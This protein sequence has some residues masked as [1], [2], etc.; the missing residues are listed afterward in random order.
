MELAIRNVTKR[1]HNVTANDDVSLSVRSGQVIAL[2]GENGA[3]KSTLMNILSGLHQADSGDITIDGVVQN[4]A[5][6]SDA[7]AAGIGMVHQHFML[8]PVHTVCENVILGTEPAGRFGVLKMGEARRLVRDIS[9]RFGLAVN[10]DAVV[11]DLPVGVQQRVE[12]IKVLLRG[13][14]VLVFDEPTAVLTPQ[15]VEEFFGIVRG[16]TADGAAVVFITHKLREALSIADEIVVMRDGKVVAHA[17]PESTSSDALAAL[18]VGRDVHLTVAKSASRPADP[19]LVVEDLSVRST[20]GAELLKSVSFEVRAGEIVGIAGVQGNGQTDLVEALTGLRF[21]SSGRIL[22]GG[23]DI[24]ESSARDRHRLG[25]AHVPEDRNRSGMVKDF[26]VGENLVL[27]SYYKQDFSRRGV[28]K[29]SEIDDVGARLIETYDVRPRMLNA[30]GGDLSGG[31]AQKMIVAREFSHEASMLVCSQPTRGVD[32]GSIEYIHEQI[33]RK[34]DDGKAILIVSTELDEI[35]SLADRVLVMFGG[36]IVAEV[37]PGTVS[38]AE[39]GLLMA[40]KEVVPQ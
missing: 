1:F 31:N 15:E 33:V 24:T 16:L 27:N 19:V 22:L 23:E 17:D 4:F 36:R 5:G 40:G 34:R 20:S 8:I 3:G 7:I 21:P 28:L 10:P 6:P 14:K 38:Q 35:L 11:E 37:D 2:V 39:L 25:L 13:A 12:I 9:E 29:R 32:I 26:T 30:R 18:M